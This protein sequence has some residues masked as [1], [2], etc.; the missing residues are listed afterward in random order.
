MFVRGYFIAK[1]PGGNAVMEFRQR[2]AP[3][4][5]VAAYSVA[6]LIPALMPSVQA[7]DAFPPMG[8]I[9]AAD[10]TAD[11]NADD[12]AAN[13]AMM[14]ALH[15]QASTALRELQTASDARVP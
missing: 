11:I 6:L 4:V 2:W 15:E 9:A 14:A 13:D 10:L 1:L 3:L 12:L 7:K 5:I 8:V